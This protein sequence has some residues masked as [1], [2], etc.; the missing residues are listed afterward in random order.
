VVILPGQATPQ[1]GRAMTRT[2]IH[3]KETGLTGANTDISPRRR[4][5][6][7]CASWRSGHL[8]GGTQP[9]L[10]SCLEM[11]SRG[12]GPLWSSRSAVCAPLSTLPLCHVHP[13]LDGPLASHPWSVAEGTRGM[14]FDFGH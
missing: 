14:R 10:S 6:S 3:H 4:A 11:G 8:S 1:G 2:R 12:A 9:G 13:C 7:S 5:G